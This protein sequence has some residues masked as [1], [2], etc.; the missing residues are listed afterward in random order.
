MGHLRAQWP[1]P[2]ISVLRTLLVVARR[3]SLALQMP[4]R[5]GTEYHGLVS[6]SDGPLIMWPSDLHAY[7]RTNMKGVSHARV[8]LANLLYASRIIT[9]AFVNAGKEVVVRQQAR[10]LPC[11][12]T[13]RAEFNPPICPTSTCALASRFVEGHS[14]ILRPQSCSIINPGLPR[15]AVNVDVIASSLTR[16]LGKSMSCQRITPYRP[17]F[18]LER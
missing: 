7:Q 14:L 17:R 15:E 3:S 8:L 4:R 2:H 6:S 9:E 18:L 10:L 1:R 11:S 12:S 5:S 13:G 16:F